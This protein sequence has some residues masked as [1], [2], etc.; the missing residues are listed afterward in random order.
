MCP[1]GI[2]VDLKCVGVYGRRCARI[3]VCSRIVTRRSA[4][5]KI[6]SGAFLGGYAIGIT[7]RRE[8]PP[9]SS[10]VELMFVTA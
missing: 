1:L 9:R 10:R 6:A 5:G 4:G 3:I 7:L 2:G 8:P